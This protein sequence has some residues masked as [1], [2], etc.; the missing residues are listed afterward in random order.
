M[1]PKI[2]FLIHYPPPVHGVAVCGGII[3]A[4]KLINDS[5][6]CQ[7]IN[8]GTSV[9]VDDIG[10]KS[11][12]KLFNYFSLVNRQIF[13]LISFRPEL[14]YFTPY[15][16]GP[17][18]YK[19]FPLIFL[20]KLFRIKCVLHYHNK[21]I[22]KRQDKLF[23]NILYRY[24]L[25]NT[26]IILLSGLLYYDIQKYIPE[27]EIHYCANGLPDNASQHK[28]PLRDNSLP[29]NKKTVQLLFLSNLIKSKGVYVLLSACRLLKNEHLDFH[30]TFAGDIGDIN[31][32]DFLAEVKNLEIEDVISY[33]GK[34]SGEI[35][36][37]LLTHS[38]VFVHPSSNDCMPLVLIEAMQFSLPIVSTFEG[39]IPDL[40]E[41]RVT[42]FLIP[43]NDAITLT[44]AQRIEMLIKDSSLRKRMGDA[45][46]R[47]FEN[48]FTL[49][50]FEG[51][52]VS[53][54][55]DISHRKY[56]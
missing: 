47:K 2:L 45:G 6:E 40:V 32:S 41:D 51:K 11:I 8:L 49:E 33:R 1:K 31:V 42:G 10:K 35:K 28:I 29:D 48:E 18:F 46:R 22:S 30:C 54:L 7:Y 17:A 24:A 13:T 43:Q 26:D 5:F 3:K 44:F 36:D 23:D 21:G 20:A 15:S 9:K 16:F 4:S 19:D 37:N 56:M 12:R 50:R 34:V 38:D 53:I 27:K 39:A 55:K 14:C 52:I 25:R